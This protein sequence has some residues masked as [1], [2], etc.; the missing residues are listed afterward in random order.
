[1]F[2]TIYLD[3]GLITAYFEFG[4]CQTRAWKFELPTFN[5][6]P[7]LFRWSGQGVVKIKGTDLI[8]GPL[9]IDFENHNKNTQKPTQIVDQQI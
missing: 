1:M 3:L 4:S 2:I 5:L 7:L 8:F 9:K 6:N